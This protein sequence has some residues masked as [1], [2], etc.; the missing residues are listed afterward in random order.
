MA[1]EMTATDKVRNLRDVQGW[2]GTWNSSDYM[3]GLYNGLELALSV[4]E[5]ERAPQFK[6]A[7]AVQGEEQG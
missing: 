5:G 1:D 6:G 4:L 7:P 3:R 2:N